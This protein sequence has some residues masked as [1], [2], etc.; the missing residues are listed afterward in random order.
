M[1]EHF[2][3]WLKALDAIQKVLFFIAWSLQSVKS[4]MQKKEKKSFEILVTQI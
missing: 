1:E 4:Y 2:E 3:K